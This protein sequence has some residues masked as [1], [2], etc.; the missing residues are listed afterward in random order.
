MVAENVSKTA[1]IGAGTMG[2]GIAGLLARAGCQVCLVDLSEEALERAMARLSIAQESLIA[3]DLLSAEEAEAAL[4]RITPLIDLEAACDGIEL[5]I[6]AM[7]EDLALKQQMFERFDALCPEGAVL[8]SNTSGLSITEIGHATN[9]PELV[10]GMHFWNPPHLIPLVEVTKGRET[11]DATAQLLM[12]ICRRIGKRPILVQHDVPG[13]VGNR[14]QFAVLREALHLLSEGIASAEDI[15]TAMTAGPGLRYGLLGPLRTADLG[16]LDVFLAISSYLF[17][18]LSSEEKPPALLAEL[19]KQG[20]LGAKTGGG[21]YPY[22]E[23]ELGEIIAQR[24]RVLLAFTKALN[25][26]ESR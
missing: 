11:S 8:A 22:G 5:L 18:D 12:A 19:V 10:A 16:G 1:V 24:D 2:A 9:R 7:S 20:K 26:K 6:E 23:E 25:E 17:A 15:D 21:F 13:F 3:A 4:G 14:L